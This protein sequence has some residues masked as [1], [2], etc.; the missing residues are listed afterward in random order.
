MK[1]YSNEFSN[2]SRFEITKNPAI[3]QVPHLLTWQC[4]CVG[5]DE[6]LFI[7]SPNSCKC[8]FGNMNSVVQAQVTF[9]LCLLKCRSG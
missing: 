7:C 8:M 1:L 3:R 6:D 4:Y 2:K 9:V 5:F